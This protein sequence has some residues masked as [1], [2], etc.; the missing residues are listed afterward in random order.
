MYFKAKLCLREGI[1]G[2]HLL[3][4]LGFP[5]IPDMRDEDHTTGGKANST[6][7]CYPVPQRMGPIGIHEA[8]AC[9]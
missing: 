5:S 4:M 2:S 8:G 1:S 3:G 9:I 6:I 7:V